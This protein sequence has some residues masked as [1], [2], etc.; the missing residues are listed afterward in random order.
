[1]PSAISLR[2]YL[3]QRAAWVWNEQGHAFNNGLAL[4]EE[5]LTEMLLLRMARDHAKHGLNVTMFNKTEEGINGADWE[6]IIRTRFCELGLR[7]QAKRLYHKDK[8]KDYGGLD[9]SSPQA[10]KLIKRAGSNIPLYVFFN[11]DHGV[12]SK[13]LH[14]GGEHPYRGRSYWGCSIACAKKVKAAGTNKL[15]DLKKHMKPWHRLVTMSGKCDAKN[16][17]GITQDEM[18]ASMPVSRRVVLENI[19]NRDFMSQYIQTE[20]LAGVAI[21]DFSDFRGE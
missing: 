11:H 12:N 8:S 6:W 2:D 4:Q 5:T 17:L 21:L 1:M 7:V 16:A 10:G 18:N 20:E 19:R 3:R 9:P 14:G 15:S 13:L